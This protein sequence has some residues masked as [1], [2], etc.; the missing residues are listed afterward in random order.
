M[1][2]DDSKDDKNFT[3]RHLAEVGGDKMGHHTTEWVI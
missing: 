3:F 2:I 1:K